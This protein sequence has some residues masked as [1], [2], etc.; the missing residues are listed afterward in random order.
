MIVVLLG[1]P[2]AGKGTQAKVLS[3]KFGYA[4]I[5]TGDILRKSVKDG[6]SV[7]KLA[8]T[9][10]DKGELV[11]DNVVIKLVSDYIVKGHESGDFLLDGFPR[12]DQQARE[13]DS[14]LK[15]AQKKVDLVLYFKT[16]PEISIERL[17]G[18][19]VCSKC[20]QNFHIKNMPSK[21]EGVCDAC[22]GSLITRGD[23][24]VETIKRRLVVYEKETGSLI[25]YYKSQNVLEE[26]SGNL[27]VEELFM[28]IKRF[29]TKTKKA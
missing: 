22:K 20:G 2:G 6:S 5:S 15:K 27:D 25:N 9:Y 13:L 26:V 7:G 12:T 17:S 14:E 3:Q 19:R 16:S 29:F 1:P 10:M 4:H 18:R 24:N 21:E 28:Q 8:K 23:D 11:P